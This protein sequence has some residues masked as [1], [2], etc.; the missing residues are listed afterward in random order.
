MQPQS[1]GY[2]EA[3]PLTTDDV[4][5]VA[6]AI[7]LETHSVELDFNLAER[8]TLTIGDATFTATSWEPDAPSGHHIT[9]VLRFTIDHPAH[10]SLFDVDQ[11]TLELHD[12]DGAQVTLNFPLEK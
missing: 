5:D 12:I 3:T 1:G 7:K 11:L 9:G 4:L 10:A 2:L 8:A 6:F